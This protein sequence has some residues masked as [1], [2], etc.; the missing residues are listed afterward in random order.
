[1]GAVSVLPA[2][3]SEM[4]EG[5]SEGMDYFDRRPEQLD[6]GREKPA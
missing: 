2:S 5:K 4:I 1:M 3:V 6:V